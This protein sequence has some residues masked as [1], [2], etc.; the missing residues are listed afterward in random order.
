LNRNPFSLDEICDDFLMF[1]S[2]PIHLI[3]LFLP[4]LA[5][6]T[7]GLRFIPSLSQRFPLSSENLLRRSDPSSGINYN[8]NGS[9]F[10]WLP[11][12]TYAGETFFDGFD[13]WNASDPTDGTVNFV[14]QSVAI[15]KNLTYVTSDGT[16]IMKADDFTTLPLGTYRDSVRISSKKSYTTGLFILDLNKA[17]WGCAVWPAFWTV[18]PDWPNG[19]EIDILEGVHDNQHNQIAWHTGTGCYLDPNATFTGTIVS[20]NGVNQTDCDGNVNSNSGCDVTEWSRAS[21]GTYFEAQGGGILAMK[22]DENYISVWSFYRAAIPKDIIAGTPNPSL[23][24][25]PSAT[26][27]D[28]LC[29]ITNFFWDHEIVFDITF[30]GQWAG[31]SYATSGCPG[32]CPQRL[33]DPTNFVNATWSINSLQVYRKQLIQAVSSAPQEH[34]SL[35]TL[36]STIGLVLLLFRHLASV[37]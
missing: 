7:S 20:N 5:P 30:C 22:W 33:V 32:T 16:V 17:P 35:V 12:D 3:T 28:T 26:L 15:Q 29:N 24:G 2:L 27:L 4:S 23:W 14:N 19:G 18:G 10:L 25:A 21:Y 13:F 36:I 8:P 11:Q 37:V 1:F 6:P 31:N 9:A 34:V